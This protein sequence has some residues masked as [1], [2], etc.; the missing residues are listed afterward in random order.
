MFA[1]PQAFYASRYMGSL[2]LCFDAKGW[3][4]GYEGQPVLLGGSASANPV[5]PDPV[6]L[7]TIGAFSGRVQE[8]KSEVIGAY[9]CIYSRMQTPGIPTGAG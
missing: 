7:Q 4:F 5:T 2:M 3:I 6:I 9:M 1:L 8:F